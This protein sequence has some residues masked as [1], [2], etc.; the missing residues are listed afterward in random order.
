MAQIGDPDGDQFR[1]PEASG[2]GQMQHRPIP[3][4]T[5]GCR[6]RGVEQSPDFRALKMGDGP[7]IVPFHRHGIHLHGK[8]ETSRQAI[9][10]IVEEGL[11]RRQPDIAR[12]D[13][14][15]A[16]GFQMVEEA[17]QE[18]GG[19]MLDRDRARPDSETSGGKAEEQD[20]AVGVACDRVLAGIAPLRQML[21]QER[22]EMGVVSR[23]V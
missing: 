6:I 22:A 8:V 12:A 14:V 17:E 2:V 4:A 15:A 19:Q 16:I 20:E 23:I 11:D 5:G 1:D 21:A 18:I 9:F 3:P 13:R 10:E 7:L